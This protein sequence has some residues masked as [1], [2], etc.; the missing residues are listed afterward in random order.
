MKQ[1]AALHLLD[2]TKGP[3]FIRTSLVPVQSLTLLHARG[4]HLCLGTVSPFWVHFML[5]CVFF[6]IILLVAIKIV[7]HIWMRGI[8]PDLFSCLV[9]KGTEYL[10]FRPPA[11]VVARYREICDYR[12]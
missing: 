11:L 8:S 4:G 5:V 6:G 10:I 9:E 2:A 1:S 3:E 12:C 7:P